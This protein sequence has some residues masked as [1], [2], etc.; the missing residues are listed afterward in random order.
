MAT[1]MI[2]F[3]A[4]K[5]PLAFNVVLGRPLLKAL[6]AVTSI[7]YLTMKFPT[8]AGIGQVRGQQGDSKDC[9]NKLL[10][11]AEMELELPKAMETIIDAHL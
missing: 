7:Y 9:Y 11:L 1:M 6:K 10:E 8:T 3:L 2:D 4:I 5:C